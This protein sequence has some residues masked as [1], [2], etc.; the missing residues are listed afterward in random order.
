M[1]FAHKIHGHVT[2]MLFPKY[3]INYFIEISAYYAIVR[4]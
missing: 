4:R 1:Y 3:Y 2:E